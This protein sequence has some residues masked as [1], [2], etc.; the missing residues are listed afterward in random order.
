MTSHTNDVTLCCRDERRWRTG[1]RSG[2]YLDVDTVAASLA[3]LVN[4]LA[5]LSQERCPQRSL[6]PQ[7]K[8]VLFFLS[9]VF[10]CCLQVVCMTMLL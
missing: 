3:L 1:V 4:P 7:K 5:F 2:S 10:L 8:F 6:R 9:F